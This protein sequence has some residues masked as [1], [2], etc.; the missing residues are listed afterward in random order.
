MKIRFRYF[1][2]EKGE[3]RHWSEYVYDPRDLDANGKPPSWFL[4]QD[5]N[6]PGP[7]EIELDHVPGQVELAALF[8]Q[9]KGNG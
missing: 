4:P 1:C 2:N 3:V 9:R 5:D 8:K 7:D 6:N